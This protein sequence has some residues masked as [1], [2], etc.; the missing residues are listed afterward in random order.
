MLALFSITGTGALQ[1]FLLSAVRISKPVLSVV[2]GTLVL[3]KDFQVLCHSDNG[4]L[5]I[6][7]SLSRPN[8]QVET[9]VVS[10]PGEQAIFNVSALS[11]A[12]DI[13]NMICRA[14]NSQHE[15]I[16]A[17]SLHYTKLIGMLEAKALGNKQTLPLPNRSF[18]C[19]T[20]VEAGVENRAQ[21]G[22]RHRGTGSDAGVLGAER[23][24]APPLHLAPHEGGPHR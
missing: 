18:V 9:R 19:R 24:G 14:R 4:S 5:P 15:P 2:G 3:G 17:E 8:K 10:N 22:G 16:M 6:T 7:Y 12:I 21:H 13:N 11:K 23:H 1:S 20:C